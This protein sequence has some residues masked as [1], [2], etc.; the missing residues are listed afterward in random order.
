MKAGTIHPLERENTSR[1][2][3]PKDGKMNRNCRL[4]PT[5]GMPLL[6]TPVAGG[7]DAIPVKKFDGQPASK[8]NG[9][10][11]TAHRGTKETPNQKHRV[12]LAAF[13]K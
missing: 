4:V 3:S 10:A 13:G 8:D 9:R 12:K 2:D 1:P 5:G 11:V 6:E 7:K